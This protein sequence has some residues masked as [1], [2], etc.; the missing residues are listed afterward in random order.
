MDKKLKKNM[1]ALFDLIVDEA[2][3]NE[4]FAEALSRIFNNETPEKKTKDN[5]GEKRASN[6]RD[7]AVLDPI[8]LAEDG[9]LTADMLSPL[10]EKELKDIVA[11]YGMDPSKLAM[12]WRD[13]ERLIQLILDTSFR[14]ASKGDA[15]RS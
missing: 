2:E 4:E 14:R 5:T 10:T 8:K 12:K 9:E 6:R 13:K 1:K 15:F 7:K 3:K 11:D